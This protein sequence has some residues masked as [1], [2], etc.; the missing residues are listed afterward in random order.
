MARPLFV[1]LGANPADRLLLTDFLVRA[2]WDPA[3]A[4]AVWCEPDDVQ[5]TDHKFARQLAFHAIEPGSF[6][7]PLVDAE[8][9]FLL[10]PLA[11]DPRDWLEP[12]PGW[13]Q[14]HDLELVKILAILDCARLHNEPELRPWYD[15]CMHFADVLLL[16]HRDAVEKKWVS[17]LERELQREA[18]PFLVTTLKKTGAVEA[19]LE[20]LFPETRRLSQ[21][22]DEPE[23]NP[24]LAESWNGIEIEDEDPEETAAARVE[25]AE[26]GPIPGD[27]STDPFLARHD[28]GQRKFK[29][30]VLPVDPA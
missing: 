18:Y 7:V 13:L 17:D 27:A 14:E 6:A 25:A 29:I 11:D 12:L 20:V 21:Y 19:P 24:L 16:S 8:A 26:D 1:V 2:G 4:I 15:A 9:A 10:P 22:F 5:T 23:T 3:H 30:S 28:A